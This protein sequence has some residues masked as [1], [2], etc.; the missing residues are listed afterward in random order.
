MDYADQWTRDILKSYRKGSQISAGCV[1][2]YPVVAQAIRDAFA[3]G[4]MT[5]TKPAAGKVDANGD[6]I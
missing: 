2:I 5:R 6:R 4:A 3:Q 1:D